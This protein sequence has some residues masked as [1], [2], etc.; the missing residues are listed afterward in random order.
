MLN[1]KKENLFLNY[2]ELNNIEL[3]IKIETNEK[4]INSENDK[5]LH[6]M[7][8][9]YKKKIDNNEKKWDKTKIY[10]NLYEPLSVNKRKAITFYEPVSRA[11]F[12]LWEILTDINLIKTEKKIYNI[13]CLCEAPG[14]FLECLINFRK[15]DF[16][17]RF[18]KY[19][20]M[21]LKSTKYKIPELNKNILKKKNIYLSYGLDNTGNIY[22]LKNILYFCKNKLNKIDIVTADGGFDY[23]QDF[24]NQEPASFRLIFC[25]IICAITIC[26]KGGHFILKFFDIF[27]NFSLQ[28]LYFLN[29]LFEIVIITKPHTSRPANSE[30]YLIC[31]NF[32]GIKQNYLKKLYNIIENWEI[33]E[34]KCFINNIFEI[35]I[36]INFKNC[37]LY[38]NRII[39]KKQLEH[40]IKTL[41]YMDNTN[42]SYEKK[43]L[44][45]SEQL[46]NCLLWCKKYNQPINN[47]SEY[48]KLLR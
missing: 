18:D 45:K 10:T 19:Y 14:G 2:P 32:L 9:N 38:H 25:E 22:N 30:K 23:S 31:K 33:Y 26:K 3:N 15:K 24:N 44:I 1:I 20:C 28:I 13:A 35:E 27:T 11:Y 39:I 8:L 48:L 47:K 4:R 36:H 7:V 16:N 34:K 12:K 21:T 17:G 40:I 46:I 43:K 42:L 29:T 5:E 6:K 41:Y 37:I